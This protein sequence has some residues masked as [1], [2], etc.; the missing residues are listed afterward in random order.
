[1]KGIRRYL[2]LVLCTLTFASLL[3]A[4]SVLAAESDEVTMIGSVYAVDWDDRGNPIA[5]KMS[6]TG[7]EYQIVDNAVGKQLIKLDGMT[8]KATGVVAEDSKGNKSLTVT[9]YEVV[10]K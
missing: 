7:E 9:S 10:S 3:C 1:M 5:A 8:V 6:G 4:A 2:V